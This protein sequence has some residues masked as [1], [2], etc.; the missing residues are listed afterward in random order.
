MMS[1]TRIAVPTRTHV[2]PP[3]Y[4][5]DIDS[6]AGESWPAQHCKTWAV[7]T[8]RWRRRRRRVQ[9]PDLWRS[10]AVDGPTKAMTI[11]GRPPHSRIGSRIETVC[12]RWWTGWCARQ[13]DRDRPSGD[14]DRVLCSH[15]QGFWPLLLGGW[16]CSASV[17]CF[18]LNPTRRKQLELIFCAFLYGIRAFETTS[19]R[20]VFRAGLLNSFYLSWVYLLHT[21]YFWISQFKSSFP[22]TCVALAI[23][24][25]R[26]VFLLDSLNHLIN[27][28]F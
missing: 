2:R 10:Y 17:K 6:G 4:A 7:E 22:E 3:T 19:T 27:L 16:L 13:D 20:L 12:S 9:K 23:P 15:F 25:S 11:R 28:K 21:D 18:W 1:G 24:Y 8:G 14:S 26:L 5:Q